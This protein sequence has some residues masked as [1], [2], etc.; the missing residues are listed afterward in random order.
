MHRRQY[1][2]R[3]EARK[4]Q[5]AKAKAKAEAAKRGPRVTLAGLKRAAQERRQRELTS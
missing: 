1:V 5:A 2:A 4:R 3:G